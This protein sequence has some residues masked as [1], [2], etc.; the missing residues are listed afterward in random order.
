VQLCKDDSRR[1]SS[2][3]EDGVV[4]MLERMEFGVEVE[5]GLWELVDQELVELEL[6]ESDLVE[7]PS[8]LLEKVVE[9]QDSW[10]QVLVEQGGLVVQVLKLI[11][12]VHEF[13]QF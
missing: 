10:Y 7:Q 13:L 4:L 2:L 8:V 3:H 9:G 11:V 5:L 12:D 1:I 6:L